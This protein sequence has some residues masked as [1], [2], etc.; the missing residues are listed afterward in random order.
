MD[1]NTLKYWDEKDDVG[2]KNPVKVYDYEHD[3]NFESKG[4][5]YLV[6]TAEQDYYEANSLLSI[7]A[8]FLTNEYIDTDF[9]DA[10]WQM[11]RMYAKKIGMM[12]MMME[13]MEKGKEL[14]ENIIMYDDR[15]GKIPYSYLGERDYEIHVPI[16]ELKVIH[17]ETTRCFLWSLANLDF[18]KIYEADEDGNLKSWTDLYDLK[19]LIMLDSKRI[20][21]I[22]DQTVLPGYKR[23]EDYM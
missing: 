7:A 10:R 16:N 21:E 19:R 2:S 4:Y 23:I 13:E 14:P 8:I 18:C 5:M 22:G 12:A 1:K 15:M 9:A 17:L 20:R 11:R 3:E 6:K